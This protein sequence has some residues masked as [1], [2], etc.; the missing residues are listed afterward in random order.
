MEEERSGFVHDSELDEVILRFERMRKNKETCYFDVNEF[1]TIIDYYLKIMSFW[2]YFLLSLK[3]LYFF[4][5]SWFQDPRN[6]GI[7]LLPLTK[8]A[9]CKWKYFSWS[10][11]FPLAESS[12]PEHK[13]LGEWALRRM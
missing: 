3:I 5:R 11:V 4:K 12:V 6:R 1:E 9:D 13:A 7:L 2:Y 10:S 8:R